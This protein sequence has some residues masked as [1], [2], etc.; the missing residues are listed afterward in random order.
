MYSPA[1]LPAGTTIGLFKI[2]FRDESG[3][4]LLP[5]AI[6]IGNPSGDPNY[7]GAES[8]PVLNSAS[9]V[10]RWEFSQAQAVAPPNTVTVSFYAIDVDQSAN[11]IY[12]DSIEAVEK[13]QDPAIPNAA[14]FRIIN[15]GR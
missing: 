4:D 2:V 10:G 5:A 7:P 1:P 12:F 9:P 14:Y 3:T 15:Q 6:T 11:T 13:V 8:V